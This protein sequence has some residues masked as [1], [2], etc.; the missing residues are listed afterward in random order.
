MT[1]SSFIICFCLF[2]NVL[3]VGCL[4]DTVLFVWGRIV[5]TERKGQW[6][7]KK[8]DFLFG[9]ACALLHIYGK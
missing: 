4:F 6:N 1:F 8:L 2:C 3:F 9:S 7:L 5:A